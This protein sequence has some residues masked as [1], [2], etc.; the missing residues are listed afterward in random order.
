VTDLDRAIVFYRD[1]LG[2]ALVQRGPLRLDAGSVLWELFNLPP[3]T[4]VERALFSSRKADRVLFVMAAP[5]APEALR[6]APR[7]P[8]LVVASDDLEGA[9]AR[10]RA[11]GFA[12]GKRQ[13]SPASSDPARQLTE[14]ILIGPG[15]QPVLVYQLGTR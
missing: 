13:Q 7:S 4:P 12:V 3:G 15:G 6:D 5:G 9:I 2:F 8:A 10:A 14:Q 1:V 11:L